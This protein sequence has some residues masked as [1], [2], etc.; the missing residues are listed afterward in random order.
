MKK[1]KR[2]DK[3]DKKDESARKCLTQK[4]SQSTFLLATRASV[5]RGCFSPSIFLPV[6]LTVESSES[7]GLGAVES[8]GEES[9]F[10]FV[11]LCSDFPRQH[12]EHW[13]RVKTGVLL[14][15]RV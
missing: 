1:K 5:A 8:V 13:S 9:G 11:T 15:R 7:V 14:P 10:G 4:R 12:E 3:K 6:D 2:N